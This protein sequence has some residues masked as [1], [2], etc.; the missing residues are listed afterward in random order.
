MRS[1]G[2][3]G[4]DDRAAD[5]ALGALT[6]GRGPDGARGA[7][8]GRGDRALGDLRHRGAGREHRDAHDRAA[9]ARGLSAGGCARGGRAERDA[10]EGRTAQPSHP[11]RQTAHL[12]DQRRGQGGLWRC[13]QDRFGDPEGGRRLGTA[14]P[15]RVVSGGASAGAG[16]A[17]AG[18]LEPARREPGARAARGALRHA[19][20]TPLGRCV[21]QALQGPRPHLVH[22]GVRAHPR[23]APLRCLP[24]GCGAL[25]RAR[26][27]AAAERA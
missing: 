19:H 5:R 20:P 26:E 8:R 9:G 15:F 13:L 2:A 6:G 1:H 14:R 4:T 16:R 12:A 3:L 21:R 23:C 24:K 27:G 18:T 22:A 17:H 25:R 7:E 11:D 10:P